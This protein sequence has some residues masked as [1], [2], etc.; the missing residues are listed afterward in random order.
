MFLL[1]NLE[2]FIENFD[3]LIVLNQTLAVLGE[4]AR[5]YLALVP[6]VDGMPP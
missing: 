2:R 5:E 4:D 6:Q 1:G 3:D